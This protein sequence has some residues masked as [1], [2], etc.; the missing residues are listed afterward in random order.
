MVEEDGVVGVVRSNVDEVVVGVVV[1]GNGR[2]VDV[3]L[4]WVGLYV[5]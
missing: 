4:C 2:F 1:G 5:V 3:L